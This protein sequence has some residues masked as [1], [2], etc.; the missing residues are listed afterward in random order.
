MLCT[1]CK[2][3][4]AVVFITAMQGDEKRNEGLCL[5]CAKELGI[6]QVREYM[7]Q[8]GID[9]D[10]VEE[11]ADQMTDFSEAV[12]G[13]SFQ[14]GGTGSLPGFIQNL[15]GGSIKNLNDLLSKKEDGGI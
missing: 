3:R 7:E 10:E 14:R 13:D 12:D 9:D 11:F 4:T 2:K 8:M 1:R 6:P 5:V 15:F